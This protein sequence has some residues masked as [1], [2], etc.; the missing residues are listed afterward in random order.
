MYCKSDSVGCYHWN[1]YPESIYK[2]CK[3]NFIT[4]KRLDY[5]EPQKSKHLCDRDSTLPRN[6]LRRYV[7]GCNYAISADD[8]FKA[9]LASPITNSKVSE[10][11]FAQSLFKVNGDSIQKI[12]VYH[13]LEFTKAGM[14]AWRYYGIRARIIVLYSIKWS[15]TSGL[16][17]ISHSKIV[18]RYP[19]DTHKINL[20]PAGSYV[21]YLLWRRWIYQNIWII[22][23]TWRSQIPGYLLNP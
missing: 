15:F 19:V 5:N 23:W 1:P 20:E 12:S 13:S 10:V 9:L 8:S 3:Q 16:T 18:F 7:D 11:Q 14:K 6:A 2:I 4:L 21:H 22:S 17:I